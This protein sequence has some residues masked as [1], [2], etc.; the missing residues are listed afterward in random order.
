[1][2]IERL[3]EL[4]LGE[5]KRQLRALVEEEERLE[6]D[7]HKINKRLNQIADQRAELHNEIERLEGDDDDRF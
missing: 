6:H 1:M 4:D 2:N 5:L 3:R 7:E